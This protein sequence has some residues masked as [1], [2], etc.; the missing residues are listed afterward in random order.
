M[1]FGAGAPPLRQADGCSSPVPGEG[2]GGYEDVCS[3]VCVRPDL[4]RLPTVGP[5]ARIS[6][7]SVPGAKSVAEEQYASHGN[8]AQCHCRE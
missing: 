5:R 4:R 6:G 2:D 3:S 1:A 7:S 8:L